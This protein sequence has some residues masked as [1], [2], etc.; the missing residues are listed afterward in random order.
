M[1]GGGTAGGGGG[2]SPNYCVRPQETNVP[3]NTSASGAP[4]LRGERD[5]QL[6]PHIIENIV[7]GFACD[8]TRVM[9]LYFWQGDDPIF[10]TQFGAGASPFAANNWH[11][12]IHDTPRI[13]DSAASQQ[14]AQNLTAS[15]GLYANTFTS[16][17][18][19][20]A[21]MIEPDGSRMLDN[22]LVLWVSELGYG[23]HFAANIP[24]VLAGM[25]SAFPQG[26]GR[27]VVENR[28]SMGDLLAHS[29]R[30]LG[31]T[32]TTY[33][34]TGTMGSH[35]TIYSPELAWNGSLP[36]STPL[37]SGPLNL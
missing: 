31:G 32:D 17:V 7:Q 6:M 22:T 5:G 16:L 24:V 37:H 30:I 33:G 8:V 28:R 36:A 4:Y 26:Q 15:F 11:G 13:Y 29:L 19:R 10:P 9:S 27:H 1:V 23:S 21:T 18:Q 3:S 14:K 25:R 12:Y 20:L 34:E 35:G 2:P